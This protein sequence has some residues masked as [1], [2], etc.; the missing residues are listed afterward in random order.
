M[1]NSTN[2]QTAPAPRQRYHRNVGDRKIVHINPA[3]VG[4]IIGNEVIS[5]SISK[6]VLAELEA[7]AVATGVSRSEIIRGAVIREIA[8]R[9]YCEA[10]KVKDVTV[11]C[12]YKASDKPRTKNEVTDAKKKKKE[13]PKLTLAQR[14]YLKR[15]LASA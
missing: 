5:T 3:L 13:E 15:L 4:D 8:F 7:I 6:N 1:L 2:T 12:G 10:S 9:K 14:E 11:L